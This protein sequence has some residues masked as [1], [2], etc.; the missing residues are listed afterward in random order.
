MLKV[1]IVCPYIK[2][3]GPRSLHQLG[4]ILF[5]S[6]IEVYMYYGYR[7]K[8]SNA[9]ELLYPDSK[10]KIAKKI[11]DNDKNLLIVPE[12]DTGW[13]KKYKSVKKVIWWLSLNFY[14]NDNIWWRSKFRTSF[15]H[16]PAITTLLRYVHTKLK[17]PYINYVLPKNL[18]N[19]DYQLYNCEYV[20]EYLLNQGVSESKMNYLCGPI[21]IEEK[22]EQEII[23][24]K[25]NLIIYNPAKASPYMIEKIL[26]YMKNN[27]PKYKFKALKNL[28]HEEVLDYLKRAKVY[29]DLGYFPG[30]ERMPREA[31]MNYCNIITST[32]G[33]AKNKFDVPIP[34]EFKFDL[35]KENVSQICELI[36]NMCENYS[37][38]INKFDK[39][40]EK[41]RNQIRDFSINIDEFKEKVVK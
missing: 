21:D 25:E 3:G 7:G 1:Y 22:D 13:L 39:Y 15:F 24:A 34:E 20:H 33:A 29:L 5:D 38:Y 18:K 23:N 14:L 19:I 35:K 32:L 27:Y 41:T 12:S 10:L 6:G 11:E 16:K 30:P 26:E 9:E 40:R 4:K 31:S 28:S 17:E 37:S 8:E 36:V 2:S